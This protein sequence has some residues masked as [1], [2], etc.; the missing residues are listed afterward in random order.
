MAI[1]S[2]PQEPRN[3]AVSDL[4]RLGSRVRQLRVERA[5]P[6]DRLALAAE[7]DQSALSK[8]E[9]GVRSMSRPALMRVANA[10]GVTME[11]LLL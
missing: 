11:E 5:L 10:L 7:V 6:Q 2:K 9:R 1:P 4:A 8:L 3:H